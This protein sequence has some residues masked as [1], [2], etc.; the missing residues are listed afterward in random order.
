MLWFIQGTKG[1]DKAENLASV[2]TKKDKDGN[3]SEE[4]VVEIEEQTQQA[5]DDRFKQSTCRRFLECTATNVCYLQL[6]CELSRHS[7]KLRRMRRH[8]TT[9]RTRPSALDWSSHGSRSTLLF[10]LQ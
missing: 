9:I 8:L 7:R 5:I 1:S 10:A 3:S 4:Q 2:T 6:C